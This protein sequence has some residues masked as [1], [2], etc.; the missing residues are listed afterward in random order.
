[1]PAP[2]EGRDGECSDV[3]GGAGDRDPHA[4]TVT[5]TKKV[6]NIDDRMGA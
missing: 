1:V 5:R 3:A 2:L 6:C 4:S